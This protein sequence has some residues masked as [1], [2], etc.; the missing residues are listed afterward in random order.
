MCV[1]FILMQGGFAL[2]VGMLTALGTATVLFVGV[3]HVR[4]GQLTLG[5]LL[6]VMTYIT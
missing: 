3:A 1:C 2:G 6:L 5:S 4:S